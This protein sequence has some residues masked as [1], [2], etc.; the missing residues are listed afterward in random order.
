[1]KITTFLFCLLISTL[2]ISAQKDFE[3]KESYPISSDGLLK[4]GTEDANIEI[5]GSDRT[6]V[7]VDIVRKIRGNVKTNK[8]FDIKIKQE[9]GNLVIQ[10]KQSKSGMS[11]TTIR[12]GGSIT[13]EIKLLVPK[14]VALDLKGEDDDY[15]I[16]N[17]HADISIKSEDGDITI[18]DAVNSKID[19][20]F[21]DGDIDITNHSGSFKA[22]AEDGDIKIMNS[23]LDLIDIRLED[24]DVQT[25]NTEMV[26]VTIQSE[27][28]D[29]SLK[30]TLNN[31]SEIT[32]RTED[33]SIDL[34]TEGEG[35]VASVKY[36]DG[37]VD[38]NKSDF[39]I[40][41]AEKHFRKLETKD[42]GQAK[43][44]IR[45]EDGSVDLIHN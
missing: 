30:S 21:E 35:Y 22:R 2:T 14:T 40:L 32:L 25:M 17:I 42:S 44:S 27:D 34:S 16:S 20:A 11:Y 1:M 23:V 3:L 45:V 28:G 18:N 41:E 31:N 36:E 37:D 19:V 6:D 13:Y 26:D 12:N 8:E 15:L 33:G 29:I 43:V 38:F 10:E 7:S 24:G 39:S 9:N 4:L 5:I